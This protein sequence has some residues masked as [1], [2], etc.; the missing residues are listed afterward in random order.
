MVGKLSPSACRTHKI[1]IHMGRRSLRV[2]NCAQP[3]L[4]LINSECGN[5]YPRKN[6]YGLSS[7]DN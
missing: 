2:Y 4:P 6:V 3:R 1:A 7:S 5:K